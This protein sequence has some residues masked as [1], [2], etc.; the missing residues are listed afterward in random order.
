MEAKHT[1]G[2]WNLKNPTAKYAAYN[3]LWFCIIE[4]EDRRII[5]KIY[6]RSKEEAEANAKLIAAAPDLLNNLE[7]LILSIMAHPDYASGEEGDEWHD[8]IEIAEETIKKATE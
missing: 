7:S 5:Q 8:L 1:P 6:G 3:N 4:S 2:P